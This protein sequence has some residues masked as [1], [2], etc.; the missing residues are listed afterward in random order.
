MA[1]RKKNFKKIR[2]KEE[3]K[4]EA[5]KILLSKLKFE[6][7]TEKLANLFSKRKNEKKIDE[8]QFHAF[9]K[10]SSKN[11]SPVLEKVA[12]QEEI[13]VVGRGVSSPAPS[14]TKRDE[15]QFKYSGGGMQDEKK[16]FSLERA[17]GGSEIRT[18]EEIRRQESRQFK[19][20]PESFFRSSLLNEVP[21][22]MIEKY[23]PPERLDAEDLRRKNPF[24]L[25]NKKYKPKLP[26][27]Y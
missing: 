9:M 12:E 1:K 5:E 26:E 15:N 27:S 8:N 19:Q 21:S 24:D 6:I 16:Y 10:L 14:I 2:I 13:V 7:D 18:F 22:N 3:P 23:S 4:K 17:P 20:S 11:V 25:D